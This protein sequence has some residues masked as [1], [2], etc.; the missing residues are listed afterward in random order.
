MEAFWR[1]IWTHDSVD[2]IFSL[3][4]QP[5]K[6]GIF[7]IVIFD[8]REKKMDNNKLGTVNFY[9]SVSEICVSYSGENKILG[10]AGSKSQMLK[11]S[12][13]F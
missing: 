5:N 10:T 3:L 13:N 8:S 11:M 4:V 12:F 2:S 6:Y 7:D 9:T 1:A